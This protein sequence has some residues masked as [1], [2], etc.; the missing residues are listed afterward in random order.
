MPR[1]AMAG[2]R[3]PLWSSQPVTERAGNR[4]RWHANCPATRISRSASEH[5]WREHLPGRAPAPARHPVPMATGPVAQI[6]QL[7][8]LSPV[9]PSCP[10]NRAYQ[11]DIARW[12]RL[13]TVAV[14][15]RSSGKASSLPGSGWVLM[16]SLAVPGGA[17][18]PVLGTVRCAVL[19]GGLACRVRRDKRPVPRLRPVWRPAFRLRHGAL[20]RRSSA[21]LCFSMRFRVV[22]PVVACVSSATRVPRA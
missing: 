1:P 16:T 11:A 18:Q 22:A 3:S 10:V 8:V 17:E 19:A 6:A 15:Y 2:P 13:A 20:R 7:C 21:G 4:N 14:R 12:L 5:G 9:P